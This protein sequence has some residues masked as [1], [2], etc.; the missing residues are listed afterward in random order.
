MRS[1]VWLSK[2]KK[3]HSIYTSVFVSYRSG[4][5]HLHFSVQCVL[6]TGVVW[7]AFCETTRIKLKKA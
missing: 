6:F 2:K 4:P 3:K 1:I 7:L 5:V